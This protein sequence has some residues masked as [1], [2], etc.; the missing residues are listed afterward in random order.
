MTANN[1][2]ITAMLDFIKLSNNVKAP[3]KRLTANRRVSRSILQFDGRNSSVTTTIAREKCLDGSGSI[4]GI[5]LYVRC[6]EAHV[7]QTLTALTQIT[8][9]MRSALLVRLPTPKVAN[10]S[11]INVQQMRL[12][13]ISGILSNDAKRFAPR[14]RGK[15]ALQGGGAQQAQAEN[16]AHDRK[17]QQVGLNTHR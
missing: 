12:Q 10:S 16:V 13:P 9:V 14:S 7:D 5:A 17:L 8:N 15:L 11:T 2:T 3:R 1:D 6:R 4:F